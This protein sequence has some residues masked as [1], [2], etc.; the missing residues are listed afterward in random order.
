MRDALSLSI[1]AVLAGAALFHPW[2]GIIGWTFISIMN[3]HRFS[4]AVSEMPVAAAIAI[5]TLMGMILTRDRVRF[6][7]TPT[8]TVF[9]LFALWMC[10]T[11]PFSMFF[12]LSYEMWKQVMKIDFMILLAVTLLHTRRHLMLLIWVLVISLAFYGVKGGIFT[13]LTG[14]DFRVWGPPDS[15]IEGNNEL[16]LAL[17]ITIPLM[18]FLQLQYRSPWVRYG[19]WLA[20]VLSAT[21]ALG[22]HSRGALLAIVAM[23]V[24][25]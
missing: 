2:L 13:I 15:F 6:F 16:A 24:V 12:P 14:G 19:L 23:A 1:L 18:R 7:L 5:A 25:L 4:W 22:T 9:I 21:S 10:I 8:L 3:P 17:V 20:M 11:L